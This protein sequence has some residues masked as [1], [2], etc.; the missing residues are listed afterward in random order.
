MLIKTIYIYEWIYENN[1][2][3]LHRITHV[4][5]DFMTQKGLRRSLQATIILNSHYF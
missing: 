2:N 4:Y 1:V 5:F 3:S